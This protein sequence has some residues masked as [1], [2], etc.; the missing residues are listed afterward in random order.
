MPNP[1]RLAVTMG[2]P[3][4]VGPEVCLMLLEQAST[5]LLSQEIRIYGDADILKR[6]ALHTGLPLPSAGA[7]HHL[8][9]PSLTHASTITPGQVDP[10]CGQAAYHYL[11][12]A[13]DDALA[14]HVDAVVTAPINKEALR[15]AGIDFPGHTEI[16][17]SRTQSPR[18]CMLQYS[19]EVTASFV[20]CHCG[21]AEVPRLLTRSRLREVIDLTH[22]ALSAI[23]GRPPI[24]R[25]LGLNPHAGEHGLFGDREEETIIAPEIEEAK[26]R[27][28]LISGPL[29]PDTA[30][31][32]HLRKTTDAFICMYHDQGH[33]PLKALAFDSAVN[34][35]LGLPIIRTSVD[36]GTAFDIAWT[37]QANPGSI[38]AAAALA[39]QLAAGR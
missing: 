20:T 38:L 11:T 13:I 2:D 28:I 27:G 33:I 9:S 23:K 25:A 30:F 3:A 19:A 18:S 35:T 16:L 14:G 39:V 12:T 31:L 22:E 15:T 1:T 17:A 4:G 26:G 8:P 37:G 5:L 24:L 32:P 7:V 36:H 10:R 21:Y 34:V 29:P 6:V